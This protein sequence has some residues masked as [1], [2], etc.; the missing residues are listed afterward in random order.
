MP[1]MLTHSFHK[2]ERTEYE[3]RMISQMWPLG[4]DGSIYHHKHD[5]SYPE[6]EPETGS[7][8]I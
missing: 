4:S 7:K 2:I 1:S 5:W 6:A 3:F 8:R